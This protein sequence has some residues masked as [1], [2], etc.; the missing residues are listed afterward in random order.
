MNVVCT[1]C[2]PKSVVRLEVGMTKV[3]AY[4]NVL[5]ILPTLLL[6]VLVLHMSACDFK[7]IRT[8]FKGETLA[9]HCSLKLEVEP[10]N[11]IKIYLDDK[12]VGRS[13]PFYD[14]KLE[15]RV[16]NLKISAP[17]YHSMQMKL[18]LEQGKTNT[19]PVFLRPLPSPKEKKIK[20]DKNK[21][22][23]KRESQTQNIKT[24]EVVQTVES[25]GVKIAQDPQ[26]MIVV[27][28]KLAG[29]KRL[30]EFALNRN[31]GDIKIMQ[32]SVVILWWRYTISPNGRLYVQ[33]IKVLG[34]LRHNR[35]IIQD[36]KEK[37][38]IGN[39]AQRFEIFRQ[40]SFKQALIIKRTE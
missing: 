25:I 40:G 15:C 32:K 23:K 37:F 2:Y 35:D 26:L 16:Y 22:Q 29:R 17:G 27:Y 13:S 5:Q 34:E 36:L 31:W 21:K 6:G 7:E 11:N 1:V 9:L 38:Y 3:K 18:S 30:V 39:N 10:K 28:N 20:E 33:A 8:F 19:V 4:K 24:P 12:L 14:E